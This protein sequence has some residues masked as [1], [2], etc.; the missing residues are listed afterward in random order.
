MQLDPWLE[1][2]L[3]CPRTLSPLK[4]VGNRLVSRDHDEYFI[5]DGVPI[6]LLEEATPTIALTRA[7]LARAK[8]TLIDNRAPEFYL[9]SLGISEDEKTALVESLK[10]GPSA[11]DP[12]VSVLIGATNG[13]LYKHLVGKLNQYPIPDLRLPSAQGLRFLDLGC[14]W[15]RW[16]IAA[17]QKGYRCVGVDP[18]LGAIM[19]ARRVA[20][21]LG[22]SP[23]YVVADARFLPF[24][25][26]VF[27]VAFSYSVL[28]HM[29]HED[30]TASLKQVARTL[31]PQGTCLV[32]MPNKFGIR[33][34]YH[35]ARRG[36]RE[37]SS[38]DVR[39]WNLRSLKKEFT[40]TVGKSSVTV[41]C[42]FGLGL[43]PS[44]LEFMSLPKRLLI[45][46]SEFLRRLSQ[47]LPG[48][49]YLADSVYVQA[50]RAE[51]KA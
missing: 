40:R 29:S 41:D 9:E 7:S 47:H 21:Q 51:G 45:Q 33:S 42:F 22:F 37:A 13:I 16:S 5:E 26:Q 1:E 23:Q 34:L 24:R 15:G 6:M 14:N 27:D 17:E 30:V 4:R 46:T 32:Q 18:S 19:A 12:A 31:K 11:V 44:D 8:D 36:F 39:Y 28:Q 38:F 10:S 3:V 35:Q 25:S 49:V 48:L 43:Q 20:R 2:N 50:T